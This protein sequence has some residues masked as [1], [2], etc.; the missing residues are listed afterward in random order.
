MIVFIVGVKLPM[1]LSR[2]AGR[3]RR[4]SPLCHHF[5]PQLTIFCSL[6]VILSLNRK[7][8]QSPL[9]CHRAIM[10]ASIAVVSIPGRENAL[11]SF[12]GKLSVWNR[13]VPDRRHLLLVAT[14]KLIMPC[15]WKLNFRC[16]LSFPMETAGST[17][18][19]IM[20]ASAGRCVCQWDRLLDE[21]LAF[22]QAG[23]PSCPDHVTLRSCANFK[24]DVADVNKQIRTDFRGAKCVSGEW[25][26]HIVNIFHNIS[27]ATV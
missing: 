8:P 10:L 2:R 21:G 18:L 6:K 25:I 5:F 20:R 19:W 13:T 14:T 23:V 7:Q 22:V 4:R 1:V 3:S 26:N 17:K 24:C 16:T 27:G 12:C 15:V 11:A 9:P